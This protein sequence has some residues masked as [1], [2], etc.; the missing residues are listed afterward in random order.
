VAEPC[1]VERELIALLYAKLNELSELADMAT[2][3][4]AEWADEFETA[5]WFSIA[6][7]FEGM[8]ELIDGAKEVIRQHGFTLP[9]SSS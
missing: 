1:G 4:S 6:L 7:N 5:Q 3:L 8:K 2:H 9:S